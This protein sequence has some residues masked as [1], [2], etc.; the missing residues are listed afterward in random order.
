V[1]TKEIDGTGPVGQYEL[2][3]E[4]VV[5]PNGSTVYG[6][7]GTFTAGPGAPD[8]QVFPLQDGLQTCTIT[9]AGASAGT[10]EILFRCADSPPGALCEGDIRVRITT[11]DDEAAAALTVINVFPDRPAEQPP[12]VV[13]ATPSFTG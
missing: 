13:P 7:G 8:T 11:V 1:V 2:E 10:D 4:C 12:A 3:V 5:E 9:E 6:F